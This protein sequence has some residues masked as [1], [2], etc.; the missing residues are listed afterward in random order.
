MTEWLNDR[1]DKNIFDL[2]SIICDIIR[3][4]TTNSFN[5]LKVLKLYVEALMKR[6]S[7]II[8]TLYFGV[9]RNLKVS[10]ADNDIGLERRTENEILYQFGQL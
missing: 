7:C 4:I 8:Y 3:R 6:S 9:W 1:Q 5:I 10:N 2:G